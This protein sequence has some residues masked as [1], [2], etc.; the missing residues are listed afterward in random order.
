MKQIN[1]G[2]ICLLSGMALFVS[3]ND[4]WDALYDRNGS[5]PQVSLMDLLRNDASL[6]TF[7]QIVEVTGTDSLL[8]SNQTYTVWAPVNEA[9]INVDMTD[10]AAL[11]RLV[12]NHIARYTNPTSTQ[13]GKYIYMLNGKRMAYDD[14]ESFNGTSL[15]DGNERAI[16]GV[17][18]KLRDTIPYRYNFY[19]YLSVYPEYSKVYEFINRFV[20][21]RYDAS[22]SVGTD[23]VFVDYNPML[24]SYYY[25]I[26]HID[27]EDSLYTMIL[28]DNAAWDKAYAHISPYFTTYNAN[29][30]VADSIRDV[31]TGQ[32][33]LNGLTFRG[34]VDDPASKDSLVTVTGNVIY[35]TSRYFAPYTKLDASNGLMYLAEGDLILDDTCTW[36]KEILVEAEYL[37]GRTTSTSTSAYVRNT[38]VNSAVQGVS[39]NSYLEVTNATGTAEVT[40]EIPQILAGKYDVYVDFVP[41]VIDGVALA[42]EKTRLEF[43]LVYPRA[44]RNGTS[45]ISRDDDDD[46]DLIIGGDSVGD[47]KVKTLKV[48]SALELPAAN[49]YDGMWFMDENNSTDDVKVRTTLRIRTNV[50]A[51]EVNVK[52]RRRFRV[53]RI[54]FVPVP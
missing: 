44:D 18:H 47:N 13:P 35:Q 26:G 17:L 15:E 19:E 33:I 48:W 25:G 4:E 27:D 29:E 30:A 1:K 14:A 38:D 22:A 43:R 24:Y 7:T 37:N 11:E 41:P 39:N 50:K 2:I 8:V 42:E 49:Y 6:S 53:D 12:K 10:R 28:P 5:V 54:R 32:A 51:S 21:K 36:N 34:K 52:Y 9:L 45:N 3:C 46:P 16:N 40:F 23:S 31:Q 20:E